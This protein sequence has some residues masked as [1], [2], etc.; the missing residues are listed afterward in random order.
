MNAEE[1]HEF[2]KKILELQDSRWKYNKLRS[3]GSDLYDERLAQILWTA[4]VLIVL[5]LAGFWFYVYR[6]NKR[7]IGFR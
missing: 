5:G 3:E 2:A 6:L 4:G 7:Q 1:L